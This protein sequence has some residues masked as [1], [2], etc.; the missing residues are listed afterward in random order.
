MTVK[1]YTMII[2]HQSKIFGVKL[3]SELGIDFII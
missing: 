2:S 1:C 3:L